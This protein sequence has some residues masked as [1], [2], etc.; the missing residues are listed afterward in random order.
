MVFIGSE[1]LCRGLCL[2]FASLDYCAPV[3]GYF[4]QSASARV[5]R[6]GGYRKLSGGANGF[7]QGLKP[8]PTR[9]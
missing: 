9:S 6:A 8:R 5:A 4:R 3:P 1:I 7:A 2:H